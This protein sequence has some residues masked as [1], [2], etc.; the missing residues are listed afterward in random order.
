MSAT[1]AQPPFTSAPPTLWTVLSEPCRYMPAHRWF[2][3]LAALDVIFTTL[4]LRTG[5]TE[6]NV[7]ARSVIEAGGLTGM[8]LFKLICSLFVLVVCELAG[9][10]RDSLGQKIALAAVAANSVAVAMGAGYL[11]IYTVS[12]FA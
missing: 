4:V 5:G 6:S 7:I 10:H 9:R 1:L 2:L 12:R 3:C 11:T 8:V